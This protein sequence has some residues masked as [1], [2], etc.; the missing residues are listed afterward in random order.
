VIFLLFEEALKEMRDGKKVR[1]KI[2]TSVYI[3]IGK[4]ISDAGRIEETVYC[5]IDDSDR[6]HRVNAFDTSG[7]LSDDWEV[8]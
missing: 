1:R 8:V 2:W 6:V 5:G 4:S 7:I 3:F